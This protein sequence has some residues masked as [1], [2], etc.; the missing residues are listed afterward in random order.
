MHE[1]E[2]KGQGSPFVRLEANTVIGGLFGP[3]GELAREE[4]PSESAGAGGPHLIAAR[5]RCTVSASTRDPSADGDHRFE[6]MF[7]PCPGHLGLFHDPVDDLGDR[8]RVV[9]QP[10]ALAQGQHAPFEIT[11]RAAVLEGFEADRHPRHLHRFAVARED[12]ACGQL[13]PRQAEQSSDLARPQQG[14]QW[15]HV[16]ADQPPRARSIDVTRVQAVD[17]VGVEIIRPSAR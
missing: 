16:L 1:K 14:G 10:R 9:D 3:Q 17:P 11:S 8:G 2:G 12:D 15:V 13:G 7:E 4:P 6:N 5:I